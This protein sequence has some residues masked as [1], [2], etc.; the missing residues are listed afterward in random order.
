MWV[1]AVGTSDGGGL[2][3][4]VDAAGRPAG[5]AEQVP[6]LAAAVA[7]RERAEAPRWI[8]PATAELYPALL[9]EAVR[10]GRCH[11]LALT[12]ALLLAYHGQWGEPRSLAAAWARLRGEPVPLDRPQLVRG[13]P[14]A[15][16][17]PAGETQ[18]ALFEPVR[19]GLP[20]G[21]D[22]LPAVL[23]VYADQ[24]R[25]IAE[26]EHPARMRLLVAAESSGGLVAAE[27]AQV[28]LPWRADLHDRLLTEVLGPRSSGPRSSGSRLSGP[29]PSGTARPAELAAL[30]EQITAALGGRPVNPDSPAELLRAFSRQGISL[31]STRSWVLRE[32][33]HPAVPLLLRYKELARLHTAHG[34]SWLDSWVR[35]GRF[36]PEYVVG[37]VV[38]GCWASRGGG[39]L[40]IPRLVRRAV[41]ADPGWALVVADAGQLEPRILAA[42]SGDRRMM[43]AA[44]PGDLYAGLAEQAFGGDRARAK[45]ALLA[46]MYGATTGGAAE[47]LAVLRRRFPDAM[48]YVEAAARAG[49]Q[50]RLVRSFLGRTCPPPGD[51]F[52]AAQSEALQPEELHSGATQRGA[53]QPEAVPGAA[54]LGEEPGV[55]QPQTGLAGGERGAGEAATGRAGRAARGR[56]RFTRN[57]VIQGTAAEWALAFL[58]ALRRRLAGTA[59]ELVF[60]QHD[61]VVVHCPREAAQQVVAAVGAAGE[62]ARRLLFG[63]TAVAMPLGTAVVECYADA[64]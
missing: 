10:V 54:Q 59:A 29:R 20:A 43:A 18:T 30:A 8:W 50:G 33:D 53:T 48:G 24:Q 14:P 28:G 21:A 12:E 26:V 55:A 32:V 22:P 58:A 64:K 17:A 15:R 61:E 2:L 40:Q 13:A 37:G 42:V 62:E 11:D 63:D 38:S 34:W 7:E 4:A 1:A 45:L 36:H 56:G 3:Q 57:F 41:L 16:A 5:P 51:G 60:F 46:A 6:D 23:A 39:A 31:A 9:R 49:E 52:W 27:M 44:G 25:R 35:G 19:G 47:L